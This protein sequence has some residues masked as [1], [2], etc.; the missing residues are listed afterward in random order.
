MSESEGRP[1]PNEDESE[2]ADD[3]EIDWDGGS[4]PR[5]RARRT[6][7]RVRATLHTTVPVGTESPATEVFLGLRLDRGFSHTRAATWR[8]DAERLKQIRGHVIYSEHELRSELIMV[9]RDDSLL[10][11]ALS[12]GTVA[13]RVAAADPKAAALGLA[14]V[15][16]RVPQAPPATPDDRLRVRVCWREPYGEGGTSRRV[17]VEPWEV[18]ARNYAAGTRAGVQRL[19]DADAATFEEQGRIIVWHGSPGTGKTHAIRALAH[20]WREWCDLVTVVDPEA[21]FTDS[22]YL[23]EV[24]TSSGTCGGDDRHKLLVLEDTGE[25]LSADAKERTGQGLSRLLN[26]CDGIA[27]Q[28]IRVIVLITTNEPVER[29]HSAVM[30]PGRCAAQVRFDALSVAEANAWLDDLGS[31]DPVDSPMTLAELYAGL[32]EPVQ[33]EASKDR[34]ERR[35]GFAA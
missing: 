20:H 35:I 11:V 2:H 33:T 26:L 29:M 28:G 30:R 34:A 32:R 15:R 18:I 10:L 21:L 4:R 17:E 23:F 1:T 7:G 12:E 27:G 25:L 22:D 19:I 6:F 31:E 3:E 9:E 8:T 16:A 14:R 24:A 5:R 13:A